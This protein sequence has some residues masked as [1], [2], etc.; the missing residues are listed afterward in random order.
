MKTLKISEKLYFDSV[1]TSSSCG[2]IIISLQP[3]WRVVIPTGTG[4]VFPAAEIPS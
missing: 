2:N 3:L 4:P 1:E